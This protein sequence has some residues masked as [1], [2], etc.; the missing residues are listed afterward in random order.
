MTFYPYILIYRILA[1]VFNRVA[2]IFQDKF[3]V[4]GLVFLFFFQES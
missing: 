2:Y 3:V 4:V 1:L